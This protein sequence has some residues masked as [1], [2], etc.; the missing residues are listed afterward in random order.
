VPYTRI[1]GLPRSHEGCVL[2]LNADHL[3]MLLSCPVTDL[4]SESVD[5]GGASWLGTDEKPTH[6]FLNAA[7]RHVCSKGR[8]PRS[9]T[10]L[11]AIGVRAEA[12]VVGGKPS[13]Q[14]RYGT[15]T[16]TGLGWDSVFR[17][18]RVNIRFDE[19]SGAFFGFPIMGTSTFPFCV[20][21]VGGADRPFSSMTPTD[22]EELHETRRQEFWRDIDPLAGLTDPAICNE[23]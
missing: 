1:P 22:I 5:F 3:S 2:V 10:E 8:L 19:Q 16:V 13:P 12:M 20:H 6:Q 21:V 4:S 9:R 23:E 7:V 18:W 17:C 11:P 14:K 15:G